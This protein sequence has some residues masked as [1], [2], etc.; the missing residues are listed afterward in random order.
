MELRKVGIEFGEYLNAD[1]V[2]QSMQGSPLE[3]AA[4]AQ[5]QVRQ[6]RESA[7]ADKRSFCFETVMSHPSHIDFMQNAREAGFETR[8]IFVTTENPVINT[9]RV[10]NRVL[11]GGHDVPQERI[12][13]R[14]WRCLKNLPAAIKVCDHCLIFDNSS[15]KNPLR[16]LAEIHDGN[17]F[18]AASNAKTPARIPQWWLGILPLLLSSENS[19]GHIDP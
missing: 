19:I 15:A 18:Q 6:K 7:V 13:A 16:L 3:V 5:A 9:G 14:Y 17:I 2:A 4:N 1:D 12:V 10:A 8:L 11:H